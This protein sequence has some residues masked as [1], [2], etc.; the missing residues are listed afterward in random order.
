MTIKFLN[1]WRYNIDID[2]NILFC[3]FLIQR[4]IGGFLIASCVPTIIA[5]L[6]GQLTNFLD[7]IYFELSIGTNLTILLVVATM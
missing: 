5:N 3:E 2:K 6:I 1:L 7:E 4:N